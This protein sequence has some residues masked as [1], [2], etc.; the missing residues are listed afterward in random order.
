MKTCSYPKTQWPKI[1][2]GVE[3]VGARYHDERKGEQRWRQCTW[4]A[5]GRI[6]ASAIAVCKARC[7]GSCRAGGRKLEAESQAG[8]ELG[9]QASCQQVEDQTKVQ[10][11]R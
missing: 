10:K 3:T 6:E 1:A 5:G 7:T 9:L 11:Q 8:L 4:E 2:Y